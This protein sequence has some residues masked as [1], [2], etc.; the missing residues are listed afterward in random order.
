MFRMVLFDGREPFFSW[1]HLDFQLQQLR[2]VK[3]DDWALLGC[4]YVQGE[5]P[6]APNGAKVVLIR[7]QLDDIGVVQAIS[8]YTGYSL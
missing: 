5:D 8:R 6:A 4:N 1:F 2:L 3:H 7:R